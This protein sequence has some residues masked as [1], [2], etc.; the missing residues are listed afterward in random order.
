MFMKCID[1]SVVQYVVEWWLTTT[2]VNPSSKATAF[3][4]LGFDIALIIP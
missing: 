3:L 1:V 2:M 4:W